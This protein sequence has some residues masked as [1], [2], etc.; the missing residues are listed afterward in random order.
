MNTV[1]ILA[2]ITLLA[3]LSPLPAQPL[4]PA[5]GV[6][7]SGVVLDKGWQS[8][9]SGNTV[10][11]KELA[12]LLSPFF[13]PNPDTTSAS[14]IEIYQGVTYLMPLPQAIQKLAI[15]Q[16][17]SPKTKIVCPGFPKDSFYSYMVPGTFE[18]DYD[19]LYLVTDTADQVV[20][21]QFVCTSPKKRTTWWNNE[22]SWHTY[23]FINNKTK[24]V[25]TIRIFHEVQYRVTNSSIDWHTYDARTDAQKR[26]LDLV[27]IDSEA[28]ALKPNS[29]DLHRGRIM[30]TV[31]WYV[32]RPLAELIL[33]CV[34][35]NG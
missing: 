19:Q 6:Q 20:A 10:S 7:S 27:R 26:P 25:N 4:A 2:F 15:T 11:M 24:A 8:P 33:Y 32:P 31:R 18:G 28:I 1:T 30:E 3:S 14:P 23:N 29:T 35:K 16:R 21:I 12:T 13:Q 17:L 34:R 9:L 5:A 22:A